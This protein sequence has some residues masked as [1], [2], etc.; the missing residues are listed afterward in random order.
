MGQSPL[1]IFSF[2]V[3]SII[4]FL[5][6]LAQNDTTKHCGRGQYLVQ[7]RMAET[8]E[9]AHF[10]NHPLESHAQYAELLMDAARHFSGKMESGGG[11]WHN[12]YTVLRFGP[13]L[14]RFCLRMGGTLYFGR[15]TKE[16]QSLLHT[17]TTSGVVCVEIYQPVVPMVG[18]IW[19]L[20]P[21][22]SLAFS[23]SPNPKTRET[24]R[25]FR[26]YESINGAP[27]SEIRY[28][29]ERATAKHE[30]RGND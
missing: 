4:L 10:T 8:I 15:K 18:Y 30:E 9:I 7:L 12:I 23:V 11:R 19:P 25:L 28:W 2:V 26:P 20:V 22:F 16:A 3:A 27:L 6:Y 14:W 1:S 13:S 24:C 17:G 29:P 5:S 21:R